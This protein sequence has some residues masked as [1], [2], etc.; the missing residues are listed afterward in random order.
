MIKGVIYDLDGTMI[1]TARLHEAAW[2][3]AA[4][5][6]GIQVSD[7]TLAKQKGITNEEG[8]QMISASRDKE[9]TE[10]L[11][12]KKNEHVTKNVGSMV[13][14]KGIGEVVDEL[15]RRGYQVWICTSASKA[16]VADVASVVG[17]V[18]KLEDKTVWREMY[19]QGKPSPEPMFVTLKKMGLAASEAIFVGDAR[20]DYQASDAAGIPFIYFCPASVA[21]DSAIPSNIPRLENHSDIFQYLNK[22]GKESYD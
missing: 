20:S 6:M 18:R 4:E 5:S 14:M 8:A 15:A 2:Q 9:E 13:E 19:D 12:E 17:L 3:S 11:V 10:M 21:P 1:D 22:S 7:D 16:F